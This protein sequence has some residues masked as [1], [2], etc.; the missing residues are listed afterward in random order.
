MISSMTDTNLESLTS[1]SVGPTQFIWSAQIFYLQIKKPIYLSSRGVMTST[2]T[3]VEYAMK[4]CNK[5]LPQSPQ[6]TFQTSLTIYF[7]LPATQTCTPPAASRQTED[8][9]HDKQLSGEACRSLQQWADWQHS[10]SPFL[11]SAWDCQSVN[12]DY[13][14]ARC[15]QA[16]QTAV[17]SCRF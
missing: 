17:W 6:T 12:W 15:G 1:D 11:W 5:L 9:R 8:Q 10:P 7:L 13:R 14:W 3:S 4:S 2:H 16:S